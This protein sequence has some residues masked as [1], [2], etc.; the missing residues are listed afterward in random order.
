MSPAISRQSLAASLQVSVALT[1]AAAACAFVASKSS[2]DELHGAYRDSARDILRVASAAIERGYDPATMDS[3]TEVRNKLDALVAG[4]PELD[5][6]SFYGVGGDSTMVSAGQP[7][8]DDREVAGSRVHELGRGAL[9]G[10]HTV[11]TPRCCHSAGGRRSRGGARG[12]TNC[13]RPT[14]AR[15]RTTLC[16]VLGL[17]FSFTIFPAVS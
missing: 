5:S 14:T 13:A 16:V 9:G 7:L 6:V 2:S 11:A 8:G 15:L 4:N 3:P 12:T 10:A 17:V 1:L